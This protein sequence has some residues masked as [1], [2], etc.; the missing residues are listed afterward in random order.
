MKQELTALLAD[1]VNKYGFFSSL[2][3]IG[4]GCIA[5][6]IKVWSLPPLLPLF[7]NRPWGIPQLG[8]PLQLF[9]LLLSGLLILIVNTTAA[10]KLYKSVVL[11]SRILLW[12]SVLVSLLATTAV[13]RI[14]LLV[15]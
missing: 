7:Y 2:T 11:L 3:L 13:I 1:R 8:S 12:V 15:T 4:I 6:L 14:I 5:F 9:F 10:L